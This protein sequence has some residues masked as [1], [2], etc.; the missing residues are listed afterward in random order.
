MDVADFSDLE[1]LTVGACAPL[2]SWIE[3]AAIELRDGI[4]L[5]ARMFDPH[6]IIVG[7]RLPSAICEALVDRIPELP[8]PETYTD[9]LPQPV[10]KASTHGPLSGAIGAACLPLYSHFFAPTGREI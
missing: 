8:R 10:I 1:A 2:D 4:A 6:A 3:R 9:D 7:G 5:F